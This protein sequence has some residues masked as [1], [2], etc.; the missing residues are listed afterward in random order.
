MAGFNVRQIFASLTLI[1]YIK[2]IRWSKYVQHLLKDYLMKKITCQ[3][4][5]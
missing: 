1:Y 5:F 4:K 3:E 2:V